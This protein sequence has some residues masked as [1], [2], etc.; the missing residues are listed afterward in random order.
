MWRRWCKMSTN[1]GG[2]SSVVR[3]KMGNSASSPAPSPP[4]SPTYTYRHM[5]MPA[6]LGTAS[7]EQEEVEKEKEVVRPC[8]GNSLPNHLYG[9][10]QA[11]LPEN[12]KTQR[13]DRVDSNSNSNCFKLDARQLSITW[14]DDDRYWCWT[15]LSESSDTCIEVAE[16]LNVCW[17]EIHGK[18]KME[19]LSPGILYEVVFI[20]MLKDPAYG[21]GVPVNVRLVLPDG[22]TQHREENLM[23]KPRGR[24]IEIP[25]GEFTSSA[26]AKNG[27]DLQF[28]LYEYKGGCWKRGLVIKGV[29]IRPKLCKT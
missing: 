21:W 22:N 7:A 24:W 19:N 3:D 25:A 16:L 14:S 4:P 17:L 26:P 5:P 6:R 8:V 9:Q 29:A 18:F 12:H 23:E 20:V 10:I 15:S 11:G 27:G 2:N 28:S 13:E 1:S